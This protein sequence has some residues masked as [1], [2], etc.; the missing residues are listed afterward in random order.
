MQPLM[1]VHRCTINQRVDMITLPLNFESKVLG[2]V[3][4]QPFICHHTGLTLHGL[5]RESKV[6]GSVVWQPFICHRTGLLTLRG[7]TR[8]VM[9]PTSTVGLGFVPLIVLSM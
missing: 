7:L 8:E 2:S 5:T 4:W 9:S 3:V 1:K 6:L